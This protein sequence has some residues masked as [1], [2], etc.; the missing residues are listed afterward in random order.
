MKLNTYRVS[1]LSVMN[2]VQQI[3]SNGRIGV[4]RRTKPVWHSWKFPKMVGIEIILP[5]RLYL[6][7][8]YFEMKERPILPRFYFK[9]AQSKFTGLWTDIEAKQAS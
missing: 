3:V 7:K 6:E 8:N 2:F 4:L 9:F 5:D 1:L